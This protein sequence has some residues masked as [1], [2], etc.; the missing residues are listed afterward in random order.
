MH[1]TP[2][3]VYRARKIVEL[4][5]VLAEPDDPLDVVPGVAT[6]SYVWIIG[7][8]R[9]IWSVGWLEPADLRTMAVDVRMDAED[10]HPPI[11]VRISLSPLTVQTL[12]VE[13]RSQIA[14]HRKHLTLAR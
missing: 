12:E 8:T 4:Q 6:G 3:P 2:G 9:D 13:L 10:A 7:E 1:G 5:A 14:H 11:V